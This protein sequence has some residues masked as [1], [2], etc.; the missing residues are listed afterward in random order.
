MESK[1]TKKETIDT[2]YNLETEDI[3]EIIQKHLNLKAD[4]I[5]FDWC[6]GQWVRLSIRTKTTKTL[7]E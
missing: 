1:I 3:E 5:Q 4:S 6:I 2:E 7:P